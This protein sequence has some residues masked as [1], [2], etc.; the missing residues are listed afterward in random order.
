MWRRPEHFGTLPRLQDDVV[1]TAVVVPR[2]RRRAVRDPPGHERARAVRRAPGPLR[3][4]LH[5]AARRAL[6]RRSRCSR[7]RR[8]SRTASSSAIPRC[9]S[10]SSRPARC[11]R[12]RTCTASTSTSSCSA[13]TAARSRCEP[14]DYFRRQCFVSVEEVEPG[15][16]AMLEAYPDSVV[17]ASDYPHADGTFPGST[18]RPARDRRSSTTTP[19][20]PRA[21]RQRLPPVRTDRMTRRWTVFDAIY[22]LRATRVY[23]DR[24]IPRRR[25]RARSSPRPRARAARATRSR[26]SSSSSPTGRVKRELQAMLSTACADV[27][28]RAGADAPSSSST[29]PGRP[30]TGHAAIENIDRVAAHRV[31]VLEPR[32]RH[33]HEGRVRGEPR[34][35]AA[36]DSPTSPAGAAR[37][38]SRRA[39]T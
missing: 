7:S 8:S 19:R 32:P 21:A 36:R 27:D 3:R 6:R 2:R 10:R 20:A 24:P 12:C 17:F 14:S 28:A 30:V 37:A 22:G 18:T 15:L 13:S 5:A 11:G 38:C 35:H 34:R 4:L 16:A 29:A 31:R 25:A 9:G 39:R 26:G 23:E 33:P 1:R